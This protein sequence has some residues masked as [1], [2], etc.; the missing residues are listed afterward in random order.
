MAVA[1]NIG[2]VAFGSTFQLSPE[3]RGALGE[4]AKQIGLTLSR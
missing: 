1:A 3:D 4:F 2:I